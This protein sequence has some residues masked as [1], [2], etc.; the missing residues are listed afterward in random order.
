MNPALYPGW[1]ATMMN[2]ATYGQPWQGM[3]TYPY[4]YPAAVPMLAPPPAAPKP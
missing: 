2:P 4:A 1:S 3:A